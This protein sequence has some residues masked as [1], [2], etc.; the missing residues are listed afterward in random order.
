MLGLVKDIRYAFR[1]LAKSPG[2][3]LVAVGVLAL[4]IG[5]NTAIFSVVNSVLL[6]PLPY[7]NPDR[8]V[9]LWESNARQGWNR[10]GVS[11][12]TYTDWKEQSSVFED[13]SLHEPGSGTLTGLG[14]P[15][16]IPGMRV[17]TNFFSLLGA[18][19]QLGRLFTAEEARG[20]RH[21]ICVVT[22]GFW[23]RRLGSDPNA[24][25]KTY[26]VDGLLYSVVGVLS[27]DFQLP[28]PSEAFVP[29]PADELR[30]TRRDARQFGVFA[31]LKPGVTLAQARAE[32]SNVAGN[33]AARNANMRDWGVTIA[34]LK[35]TL[36]ESIRP[37]LVVLVGAVAFVLLIACT[38]IANLLL[39]R[40]AGRMKEV[41]IRTAAGASRGRLIQQFLAESVVLGVAGGALGLVAASWGVRVLAAVVPAH[42][43]VE[44]SSTPIAIPEAAIDGWV[45][46]FTAAVAIGTGLLFGIAPAL[47]A[48]KVSP[49][50]A[51]KEGGRSA[52][53][54][55]HRR[56][57][58]ALVIAE[59]ALALVLLTGAGL[60]I[61]SFHRLQQANPGFRPDHVLSVEMELPTDTRYRKDEERPRVFQRF[62]EAVQALPGVR[63]AALTHIVP[64]TEYEDRTSFEIQ[65]RTAAT[66]GQRMEADYRAISPDYFRTLGIPLVSGRA[67]NDLDTRDKP[68]VVVVDQA[69]ARPYFPNDNPVGH[70][71]VF[72]GWRTTCDIVGVAGEVKHGGLNKQARPTLYFPYL[73][74]SEIRMSLVVRTAADPKT[75]ANA[76]KRAVW[77]VDPDQ[78]VYNVKTMDELVTESAAAPRFTLVLLGAFAA[79]AL[80]LAAI[81]IYGVMSYTVSQRRHE[82]GIRIALG[83]STSDVLRLVVGGALRMTLAG[84]AFGLVG[85]LALT[86]ALGSLLYGVSATD[87][88]TFLAVAAVLACVA[89]AAAYLPARRATRTSPIVALRYE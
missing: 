63:S 35:D 77:S 41:A 17:T 71:L 38:N 30:G 70:K 5:A 57:R 82:M 48:T 74:G 26:R 49:G 13:M 20:G 27:P 43:R 45:L 2:F 59:V 50:E 56:L 66:A 53:A 44:G 8:L 80:A 55:G 87:P 47:A 54:G 33:V 60:M 37:A 89:L 83:A 65:G 32:M 84:L 18:K 14:E 76:V 61:R 36:V 25:G 52:S 24:I 62:L 46:L 22:D 51:L 75:F 6:R 40:G 7:R 29:W 28:I 31:R 88:A 15:E 79:L 69:L 73:I 12:A 78:P 1:T 3:S 42:L 67:F 39:A 23:R 34:P 4:G 10:V 58:S 81:G 85:A 72:A 11:G 21:N 64:L 9:V 86:R 16:Q 68:C 19:A